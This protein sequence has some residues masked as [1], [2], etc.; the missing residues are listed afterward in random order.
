M[1]GFGLGGFGTGFLQ[2]FETMGSSLAQRGILQVKQRE[3]AR[4]ARKQ[5]MDA[6][7]ARIK[8]ERE[9]RESDSTIR[10]QDAETLG[11]E[12]KLP[13]IVGHEKLTPASTLLRNPLLISTGD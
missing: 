2:G 4:M 12:A 10:H 11:L 6:E 3:E 9:T 8:E 5:E 7:L 13:Y 1:S